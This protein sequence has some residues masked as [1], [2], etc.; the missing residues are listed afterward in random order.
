MSA[1]PRR[2]R[3]PKPV[4]PRDVAL[5]VLVGVQVRGAYGDKLAESL[6]DKFRLEP[7]D[8]GFLNELVKGTLKRRGTL[9]AIV[10][11]FLRTDFEALPPWIQNAFRLGAYQRLYLDRIPAHAAVSETVSLARKYGHPG[12]AGLVNSVLRRMYE[13]PTEELQGTLEHIEDPVE[14]LVAQSSHPRWLIDRWLE[15][16]SMDEVRALTEANNRTARVGLRANRLKLDGKELARRLER[17]GL[18]VSPGQWAPTTVWV[19]GEVDMGS[20]SVMKKGDATVQDESETLVGLMSHLAPAREC[21]ICARPPA[22][23]PDT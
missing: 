5:Q 8:R 7:V 22:G 18:Q 19:D 2:K 9:D 4:T 13:A 21:S 14:R 17:E 10:K 11:T 23:R 6:A 1:P 20:L 16:F 12:T 3:R 15:R